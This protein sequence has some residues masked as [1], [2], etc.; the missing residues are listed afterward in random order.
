MM[1]IGAFLKAVEL[2][3]K[4]GADVSAVTQDGNNVLHYLA[5]LEW[6][7]TISGNVFWVLRK[8][9]D[10]FLGPLLRTILKK[11]DVNSVNL[12]NESPLHRASFAG[13]VE[14]VKI[15][16]KNKADLNIKNK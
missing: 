3:V 14:F 8:N 12:S 1:R 7:E 10:R 9:N 6:N 13:N 16:I 15:F 5:K 4:E 11:V 2:L